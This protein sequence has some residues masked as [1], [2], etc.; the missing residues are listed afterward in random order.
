MAAEPY[1]MTICYVT[2]PLPL[3]RVFIEWWVKKGKLLLMG[4]VFTVHQPQSL[5]LST[6]PNPQGTRVA[7]KKERERAMEPELFTSLHPDL[8]LVEREGNILTNIRTN[9]YGGC[10]S[11][12]QH[13]HDANIVGCRISVI[14]NMPH[15]FYTIFLGL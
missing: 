6:R 9:I 11:L 7:L 2:S 4:S 15:P 1:I 10:E 12:Q 13:S 3:W 8:L 5:C 14:L